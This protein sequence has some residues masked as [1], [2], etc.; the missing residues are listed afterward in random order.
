MLH[1]KYPHVEGP[2]RLTKNWVL[3][4][5]V[6]FARRI[7]DGDLVF[8]RPG[9]TLFLGL[10]GDARRLTP[11]ERLEDWLELIDPNAYDLTRTERD[12]IAILSYRLAENSDDGRLPASY[13]RCFS[14]TGQLQ[15]SGYADETQG[16]NLIA[17]VV[18]SVTWALT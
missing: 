4:L 10:Y 13:N 8:W 7:E 14:T 18:A 1:P 6:A 5:P 17:Q 9:T 2:Q 3:D 12:G 16:I 15:I 11:M